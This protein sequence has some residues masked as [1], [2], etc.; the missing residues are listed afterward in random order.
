M[1]SSSDGL[2]HYNLNYIEAVQKGPP[3]SSLSGF[4]DWLSDVALPDG[5]TIC[6]AAS[7]ANRTFREKQISFWNLL[8]SFSR[9]KKRRSSVAKQ[10]NSLG[11]AEDKDPVSEVVLL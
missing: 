4:G 5:F 6:C 1:E 3:S 11:A 7:G 8:R 9:A 10:I 2:L